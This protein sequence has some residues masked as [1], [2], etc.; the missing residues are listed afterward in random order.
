MCIYIYLSLT[1]QKSKVIFDGQ[2]QFPLA[3][4][5]VDFTFIEHIELNCIGK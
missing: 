1:V 2:K 4:I 3:H 5:S